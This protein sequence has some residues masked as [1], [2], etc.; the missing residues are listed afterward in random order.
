MSVSYDFTGRTVV[1]T[2][3]TRGI[4]K[5]IANAYRDAGADLILTGT[6]I[7]D[8]GEQN[9]KVAEQRVK[10]TRYIQANFSDPVSLDAF[11]ST[12]E[13]LPR[14]D[15]LV[16]NAGINRVA[17][18]H[19]VSR[20]DFNDILDVN[21]RAPYLACQVAAR[22]MRDAGYGRILNLAS[23]WSEIT[24]P[25][26]S[27][28]TLTKTGLVGLTRTLAVELAPHGV[29]VNALSP[30]F[31]LTELTRSTLAPEDFEALASQVPAQRFAAPEEMATV[32]LFL[33]SESNSYLTGQNIVVDG[34]FVHV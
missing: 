6:S 10:G 3:A 19:E 9:R 27:A 16:N 18:V 29:V 31:T 8:V 17:P 23:I 1:V 24:K 13:S 28:Y 20:E 32:A 25:G 12:L 4:G 33:T 7:D 11:L 15:V 26:R 14:L 34:G 22:R 21:L 5:A 2:G 30:G